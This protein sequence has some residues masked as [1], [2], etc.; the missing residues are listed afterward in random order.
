MWGSICQ[1][2]AWAASVFLN[3]D[4]ES[5]PARRLM[6]LLEVGPL[7]GKQMVAVGHL[8]RLASHDAVYMCGRAGLTSV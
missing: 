6:R 5:R 2:N 3:A 8:G 4:S 1:P 7:P